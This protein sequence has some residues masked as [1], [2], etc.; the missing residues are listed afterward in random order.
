MKVK[1]L[2]LSVAPSIN[3]R[4]INTA[5][6]NEVRI[7]MI[8]VNA[9]PLIGPVPKTYKITPVN[10]LVIFASIIADKAP[11]ILNPY[12]TDC[13][14]PFFLEIPSLILSNI[15]TLAST[16]I[17]MVRIIPAI[18]G[19]VNTAL[20]DAKIPKINKMFTIKATFA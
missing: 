2:P 18:P 12:S 15:I 20:N 16:D 3:K 11:L 17:P 10:K 13:F 6:N 1:F 4:V 14:K 5:V 19:R 9:K 8:N 7:P